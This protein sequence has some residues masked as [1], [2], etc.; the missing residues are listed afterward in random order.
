MP[1][2]LNST[3]AYIPEKNLISVWSVLKL[4]LEHLDYGDTVGC[5]LGR[6]PMNVVFV[7]SLFVC[8]LI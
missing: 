5:T 4:L 2:I 1:P 6:D 7:K 3:V 8:V